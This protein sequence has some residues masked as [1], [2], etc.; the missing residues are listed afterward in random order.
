MNN[1]WFE[2]VIDKYGFAVH[3]QWLWIDLSW[4]LLVTTAAAVI[5]WR[6]WRWFSVK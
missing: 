4:K 1:N 5:V 3:S 2:F 6:V